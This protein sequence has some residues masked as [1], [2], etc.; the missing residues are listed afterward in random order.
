MQLVLVEWVDIESR[1]GWVENP[2]T[3]EPPKFTTVGY[4]ILENEDKVLITD[5]KE[6]TGNVTVFPT[7]C[8]L[9]IKRLKSSK[10]H[11]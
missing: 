4:L 6:A 8:I 2:E 11:L 7:G 3:I 9:S 10:G 5:T 1:V